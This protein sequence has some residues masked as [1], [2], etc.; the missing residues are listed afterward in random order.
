MIRDSGLGRQ[1]RG[2]RH[3][4]IYH[5][6]MDRN[7]RATKNKLT[8]LLLN[9]HELHGLKELYFIFLYNYQQ[10]YWDH[11]PKNLNSF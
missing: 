5:R 4:R 11:G 7:G 8:F 3:N 10:L 2:F 1:I 9:V 6:D